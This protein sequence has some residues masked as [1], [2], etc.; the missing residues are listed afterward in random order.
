M[1]KNNALGDFLRARREL[2]TP[3]EAGLPGG[4]L[5]RV[6]GLRR[7]EVAMLAGISAEYYL[8]LEQGRD[9]TPSAQVVE[10]LAR[11]LKLDAEG[12]GYL[13]DLARPQPRRTRGRSVEQVPAGIAMLLPTLN[14][15]AFVV[16]RYRDVLAAN[17]L[18][19]SLSPLM[20]PGTNRLVALFT[21]P[22]ARTYHPDLDADIGNVVAQLRAEMGADTDD[23]RLQSL[24]GEL[25]LKSEQ[26]R[27]LWARHD[28]HRGG[29][30]TGVIRHPQVGEMSLR[31]EKL[32]II[33]GDGLQMVVYHAEPGSPAADRL[34][35]LA[36]L[37]ASAE[38]RDAEHHP[39]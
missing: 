17:T 6:P 3:A 26:F 20:Q 28:I 7:E 22:Q 30:D 29:N 12:A 2:V 4:G 35:L 31:R 33:G 10:A 13:A 39:Q 9:R 27:K 11:V 15:P 14:V 8:R 36:T 32:A 5:R 19:I 21:D 18:A 16:N 37:A 24:I 1:S 25:S 23:P 34:V 38:D